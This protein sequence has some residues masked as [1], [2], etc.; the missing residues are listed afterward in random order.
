MF[1]PTL[2]LI[3][4]GFGLA[5]AGEGN[6]VS[7]ASTPN[8]DKLF[9]TYPNTQ[10]QASGEAVGLPEGQMGNSEVGHLNLG[11]GRIVYQDIVRINKAIEDGSIK[12]NFVLNKLAEDIKKST[13][14][15]H[16]LGLVSD[17]GV[18]S[19]QEHLHYLVSFFKQRGIKEVF[20]HC[21]LDG[22]DTPPKSALNYVKRLVNFLETENF[23]QIASLSG[24]YFAMDRDKHWERTELAYNCLVLGEGRIAASPINA[25]EEAYS[26]GETDEFVRPTFIQGSQGFLQDGDGVVFFNFRAD[27]VRQLCRALFDKNF[28][29]FQR[30]KFPKLNIITMTE[31]DHTFPL[32]VIFSPLSLKNILGE[33]VSNLGLKQ[34]RIAETE[35]YAHVTYFFNGGREEPFAGEERILV[36]SPREVATYDEKPEMSVFE[37]SKKLIDKIKQKE[38]DFYV[39]NFANLDMVGHTGV[40]PAVIKACEAVDKCVGE[41][42]QAMLEVGGQVL[43]TADHGNAEDMLEGDK[44]KTSHSTNPVPLILISKRK[45]VFLSQGK[46][47]D[48]A[49]TILHLWQIEKPKEMTGNSLIGE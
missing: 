48:I 30:K 41:V 44:P 17:G 7:L 14:R 46:L 49:P 38:F 37:V 18:H 24:R 21:F 20:I 12:D 33:V 10:L 9:L 43:L 45:I 25:I 15:I 16:L 31:Y 35:K 26:K 1:T 5:P 34:L 2:L 4:D 47:G 27:R 11:A 28:Q 3:L 19:L 23:G 13:N 32:P 29:E 22:R 40:I 42:V 6:A 8:L 36:P 39:C